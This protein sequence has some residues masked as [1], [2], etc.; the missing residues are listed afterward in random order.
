MAITYPLSTPSVSGVSS[1]RLVASNV[2]SVS[3]SPFTLAQQ[4][5]K[6]PGARWEMDVTLA[7]MKREQAEQWASFLISL[8]GSYGTFLMGDPSGATARGS[9]ASSPGTPKV[10]GGSQTGSEL[11]IDGCPVSQTSYLLPGDYIQLGSGSTSK[12]HKVLETVATDS[13]GQ[14]TITIWP[15]LRESPADDADITV[16]DCKGRFRLSSS[17]TAYD[18]NSAEVYGFSFGAVEAL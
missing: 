11:A 10:N 6:H 13:S 15:A 1:V 9:A 8:D 5:V 18:I 4:V 16:S 17:E 3:T 12:L 14:A 2:V 7:P